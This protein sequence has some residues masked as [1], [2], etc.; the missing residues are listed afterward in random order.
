MTEAISV[1][2]IRNP[3]DTRDQSLRR[4][5]YN[6]RSKQQPQFHGIYTFYWHKGYQTFYS[7]YKSACDAMIAKYEPRMNEYGYSLH[8]PFVVKPSTKLNKYRLEV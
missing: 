4:R 5:E 7:T 1:D 3:Q 6:G 2:I 8:D